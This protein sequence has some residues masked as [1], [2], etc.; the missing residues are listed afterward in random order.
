ME[1]SIEE[2]KARLA[3]IKRYKKIKRIQSCRQKA[4]INAVAAKMLTYASIPGLGLLPI[5]SAG[6]A[7]AGYVGS[8][9]EISASV[10]SDNPNDRHL[11]ALINRYDI[12]TAVKDI[13]QE[14]NE[15]FLAEINRQYAEIES[16]GHPYAKKLF[17]NINYCNMAVFRALKKSQP[18][19][20][21]KFLNNIENPAACENF[22]KYIA[23]V[24]PDCIK[25]EK[26]LRGDKVK[27]GDILILT[28]QPR[29]GT[30][31]TTSGKHTV[32]F[33][34]ERLISFNSESKYELR[35]E[36]G[37][38]IDMQQIREKELNRKLEEMSRSEAVFY[39]MN[40]TKRSQL[41]ESKTRVISPQE[42]AYLQKIKAN[43]RA[44]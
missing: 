30:A 6:V 21:E 3:R 28:N 29:R 37:Y 38:V 43:Q 26:N 12:K 34:G 2:K 8:N 5:S 24:H 15:E 35:N 14:N 18:D 1:L 7:N 27:K 25:F 33:D 16:K 13:V 42:F 11:V 32:T 41:A 4:R 19:Y 22:R 39:L 44:G 36:S 9:T 20:M 40:L 31:V 23:S 10:E 17:G